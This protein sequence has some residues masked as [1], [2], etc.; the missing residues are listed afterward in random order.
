MEKKELLL[1]P[2][3]LCEAAEEIAKGKHIKIGESI[4]PRNKFEDRLTQAKIKNKQVAENYAKQKETHGKG[5]RH[6]Q[7]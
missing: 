1:L 2:A 6:V 7:K 3:P 4:R 5:V